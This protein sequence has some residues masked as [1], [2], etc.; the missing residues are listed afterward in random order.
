MRHLRWIP[1]L[2][3]APLLALIP[4]P[5]LAK[6]PPGLLRVVKAFRS[7]RHRPTAASM[8]LRY[9]RAVKLMS[10]IPVTSNNIGTL[11]R[12]QD[13]ALVAINRQLAREQGKP[14]PSLAQMRSKLKRARD[15]RFQDR[16]S[17][18]KQGTAVVTRSGARGTLDH[19]MMGSGGDAWAVRLDNGSRAALYVKDL[20]P[21]QPPRLRSYGLWLGQ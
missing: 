3:T 4:G 1:L 16:Y 2:L 17:W 19:Y 21:A 10:R 5:S 13:S 15:Q 7:A 6:R 14:V 18:L 12:A 11:G 20:R 8:Q 9:R